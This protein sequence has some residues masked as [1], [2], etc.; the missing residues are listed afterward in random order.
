MCGS[1]GQ[2]PLA[3]LLGGIGGVGTNTASGEGAYTP[4]D[5][6]VPPLEWEHVPTKALAHESSAWC[7]PKHKHLQPWPARDD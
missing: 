7:F 5:G 6:L 2:K 3:E 4:W 1:H